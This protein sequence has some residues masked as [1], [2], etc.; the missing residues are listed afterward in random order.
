MAKGW[1]TCLWRVVRTMGRRCPFPARPPRSACGLKATATV[2][3]VR[4]GVVTMERLPVCEE[5]RA[6]AELLVRTGGDL[7]ADG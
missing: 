6:A 5:H 3:P 4:T 2:G 1:T 7:L